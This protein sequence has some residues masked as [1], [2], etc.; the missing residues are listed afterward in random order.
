MLRVKRTHFVLETYINIDSERKMTSMISFSPPLLIQT[1]IYTMGNY[2]IYMPFVFDYDKNVH[3]T[4]KMNREIVDATNEL[5]A[6]QNE[7]ATSE[8]FVDMIGTFAVK[9]NENNIISITFSNYALEPFAAHGMTFMNAR[10]FNTVTGHVY[11]LAE[12]FK[13]DSDYATR[14]SELIKQQIEERD[15]PVLEPFMEIEANASFYITDMCLVIFFQLYELAP[16]A[17][18]IPRFPIPLFKLTDIIDPDGPLQTME[19]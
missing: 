3:A 18:G 6:Q 1:N 2:T 4:R 12:M 7:L 14:I 8:T 5:I 17:Y 9:T 11:S 15:I 16:Y 13:A 19:K 10:T